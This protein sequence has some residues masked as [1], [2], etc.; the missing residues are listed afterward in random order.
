MQKNNRVIASFN[1]DE[2]QS[3]QN[4]IPADLIQKD[5]VDLNSVA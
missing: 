2:S 4:I 3:G 5:N 1:M